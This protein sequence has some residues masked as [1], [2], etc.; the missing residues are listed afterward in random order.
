MG[1][2]RALINRANDDQLGVYW[3]QCPLEAYCRCLRRL[4]PLTPLGPGR[5]H[6]DGPTSSKLDFI[7]SALASYNHQRSRTFPLRF[8]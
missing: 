1:L 5:L 4:I 7:C 8:G 2:L 3:D 6:V